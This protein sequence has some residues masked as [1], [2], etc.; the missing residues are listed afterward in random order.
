MPVKPG[1]QNLLGFI[2]PQ[3][4]SPKKNVR[5]SGCQFLRLFCPLLAVTGAV[6]DVLETQ[7][8]LGWC[9]NQEP[10][11]CHVIRLPGTDPEP[12]TSLAH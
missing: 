5:D 8:H 2:D 6:P 1:F 4:P 11:R 3:S 9:F 10:S 7:L 12:A